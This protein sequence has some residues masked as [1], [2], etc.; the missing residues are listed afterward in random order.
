ML[1]LQILPA[2][3]VKHRNGNAKEVTIF[4]VI[5]LKVVNIMNDFGTRLKLLREKS[6]MTQI[7]LSTRL[8]MS[9][10]SISS[11]ERGASTPSIDVLK[12]IAAFFNVSTDYLLGM[13]DNEYRVASSELNSFEISL[14][15]NFKKLKLREKEFLVKLSADMVAHYEQY[16]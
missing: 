4:D 14:L 9:Q 1:I 12:T 2:T 11:Y 10:E 15:R 5:L 13:D 8:G 16:N 3:L 6:G 7:S